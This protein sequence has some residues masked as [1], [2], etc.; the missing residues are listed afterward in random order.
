[1]LSAKR[2]PK[3]SGDGL[4]IA[5]GAAFRHTLCGA[6]GNKAALDKLVVLRLRHAG[7]D[8]LR[9][10]NGHGF[11]QKAGTNK[12]VENAP[13]LTRGVSGFFQQFALRRLE[14]A[15]AAVDFA[16]RQLSAG[17]IVQA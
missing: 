3:D 8:I 5:N 15:L 16:R 11:I 7:T 2:Q 12:E 9:K 1:M 10:K 17:A 14:R 4:G 6:Q 13:P